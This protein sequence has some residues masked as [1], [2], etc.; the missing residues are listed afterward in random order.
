[1]TTDTNGTSTPSSPI[2]DHRP[3][4]RGVLPRQLQMWLMVG[5]AVV[6]LLIILITGHPRPV[7]RTQAAE[8]T[9]APALPASDRIRAY[10]QQLKDDEAR[11]QHV[12]AQA[13]GVARP[14]APPGAP[15]PAATDPV[16]DEQRRREYQSLFADNVVLSRR[17]A[18]QQP[19]GESGQRR[20]AATPAS[21]A[22]SPDTLA[23][24]ALLTQAQAANAVRA[25][26]PPASPL[27][28]AE[29][30]ALSASPPPNAPAAKVHDENPAPGLRLRLLEGTVI[31]TV[32]L[33]RLDGTFAGPVE[34]LVT[35]P[36]YSHDRQTVLIPA[37]AR[38]LGAAA[39]V[40]AWGDARLAVSF[41]RL[42]M[43]DGHTY[44]LDVFKG[45]G[46]AGEIGLKDEVNRHYLQVFGASLA[47]GAISGLAQYGTHGIDTNS[48]SDAYRQSAGAS[49]ATSS[50]RVLDRYLNV[51]PT[52]T[53]REGFR[54]KVYLTNDF[55][56]PAYAVTG[57]VQ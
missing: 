23:A 21:P 37:G 46:Q 34:C 30:H 35:T 27:A 22:L 6:I 50:S 25:G 24:L 7:A 2:Q 47:I 12:Q 17:A 54:I 33:N 16:A 43:P 53:I 3:K 8:R 10:Q 18:G 51:L 29:N 15:A 31:E 57:G 41:H 14:T 48:F 32:L 5:I 26:G 56:L 1:M 9:T 39:P 13:A 45:L 40:Q 19:N 4:P 20:G 42:I 28:T 49:L 44:S 52:V 38:V 55:D 36:V 11:L